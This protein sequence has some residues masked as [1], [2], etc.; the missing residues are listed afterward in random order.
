MSY[1]EIKNL[2]K[3]FNDNLALDNVSFN[4]E[5]GEIFGL[6]GPNGAGKSTLINIM[7]GLLKGSNGD[8][9]IDSNSV[10]KNSLKTKEYIGYVPQEIVLHQK[11]SLVDNLKY[12]GEMYG[13]KGKLLKERMEEALELTGL[14][15]RKK[16]KVKTFSGGMKRRLNIACAIMH[17]PKILIMDEPTVG[18]DPQSRNHILEFTKKMNKEYGTTIIYTSHYMEEVEQICNEIAIIDMG[19]VIANGTKKEIKRLVSNE[20]NIEVSIEVFNESVVLNLKQTKGIKDCFYDE[21][22]KT[23]YVAVIEDGYSMEDI[24]KELMKSKVKIKSISIIEPN[25]EAVFL[26]LT[27]KKLRD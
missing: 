2:T 26:S 3:R 15:E 4:I 7:C 10:Q 20:S 12:W 19:N 22:S 11:L 6:L 27:G 16:D 9:L 5:K 25:L 24:M 14:K 21:K 1:I 18:I 23:L 17:H 13:L 8:I